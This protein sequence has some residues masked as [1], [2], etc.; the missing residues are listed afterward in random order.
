MSFTVQRVISREG[1]GFACSRAYLSVGRDQRVYLLSVAAFE[2]GW[3][4][5]LLRTHLDGSDRRGMQYTLGTDGVG[6]EGVAYAAANA[7]GYTAIADDAGSG[8]VW[9][10][11]PD[12][13]VHPLTRVGGMFAGA[14]APYRV[15]A[16]AVSGRFY[17]L[18]QYGLQDA[19]GH[20]T[21]KAQISVLGAP[22]D[23]Q[24]TGLPPIELPFAHDGTVLVTDFRVRETGTPAA[25]A[26]VFYVLYK[27]PNSDGKTFTNHLA[28]TDEHGTLLWNRDSVGTDGV[29]NTII[30]QLIGENSVGPDNGGI[31]GGF[32][33]AD[34]GHIYLLGPRGTALYQIP[35]DGTTPATALPLP[36]DAPPA[37]DAPYR[38]LRILGNQVLLQRYQDRELYGVFTLPDPATT[39][40][41]TFDR[42]VLC[43]H[44]V[45]TATFPAEAAG[46]SFWTAGSTVTAELTLS[47][48]GAG[49]P[50]TVLPAPDWK[51]WVRSVGAQDHRELAVTRV[52]ATTIQLAVPADLSG[53]FQLTL[54]PNTAPWRTGVVDGYRLR[55]F[56]EVRPAGVTGSVNISTMTPYHGDFGNSLPVP[57]PRPLNRTRYAAGEPIVVALSVRPAPSPARDLVLRLDDVSGTSPVTVAQ[58]TVVVPTTGS[59]T[60]TVPGSVTG[61]LRPGDYLLTTTA[62]DLTVAAQPI[63]LGPGRTG[64]GFRRV[65][66]GDLLPTFPTTA[67]VFTGPYAAD[68]LDSAD[69]AATHLERVRRMGWT[70]IVDRLTDAQGDLSRLNPTDPGWDRTTEAAIATTASR[71]TADPHAVDP[72]KIWALP[73][74]LDIIGGYGA[75]GVA[76]RSILLANDTFLP[77]PDLDSTTPAGT[78]P[79]SDRLANQLAPTNQILSGYP[80]FTGWHWAANWWLPYSGP[81]G[82]TTSLDFVLPDYKDALFRTKADGVWRWPLA[83]WF[84]HEAERIPAAARLLRKELTAVAESGAGRSDLVTAYAG[85]PTQPFL[86][87]PDTF[88][89][90]D[91][92]DLQNQQEQYPLMLGA[93]FWLDF[94]RRPGKAM[95]LHE[96][97]YNDSGTGD[98]V[99]GQAFEALLRGGATSG[100]AAT[101]NSFGYQQ[102][103]W[104]R[105]ED[106]LPDPRYLGAGLPGMFRALADVLR[107]YGEWVAAFASADP[108][109]ILLSRRQFA[110]Q[111]WHSNLPGHTGRV[112]EAYIS[113]LYAHIPAS[114]VFVE[115]FGAPGVRAITD[116]SAVLLINERVELD[117]EVRTA[118]AAARN[119]GVPIFHD[120]TTP[121]NGDPDKPEDGDGCLESVISGL[122]STSLGVSFG[123]S[124]TLRPNTANRDYLFQQET[125]DS[126]IFSSANYIDEPD[127]EPISW[128]GIA[129]DNVAALR[130]ALGATAGLGTGHADAADPQVLISERWHGPARIVLAVNNSIFSTDANTLG[131]DNALFRRADTLHSVRAPLT[132]TVT[133]P[134]LPAGA[135]VY[136][137]FAGTLLTPDAAGTVP[138]DLRHWP[139]AILAV[140]PSPITGV[141]VGAA[142]VVGGQATGTV[143]IE[144]SVAVAGGSDAN[145]SVPLPVRVRILDDSRDVL[146]E[147]YTQAP[148]SGTFIVPVNARGTIRVEAV[149]LITGRAGTAD[150]GVT[151][152]TGTGGTP[153]DLLTGPTP[154]G[155]ASA[156]AAVAPRTSGTL[157]GAAP[158]GDWRPAAARLGAHLS[159]VTLTADGQSAVFSAANWD[160]NLYAVDLA[161]G[162]LGW[163]S[164]IG[165]QFS[166]GPR[167]LPHAVSVIGADLT[168]PAEFGLHM[169]DPAT[170]TVQRRFDL[171]GTTPRW[172]DRTSTALTD[173][174]PPAFATAAD[175]SWVAC[176]G[177]LG[178]AAWD[179]NGTLLWSRANWGSYPIT[180]YPGRSATAVLTALNATT[181]LVID[182]RIATGY[183]A[184]TGKQVLEADLSSVLTTGNGKATA[185]VPSPD[186]TAVAVATSHD[187]GRVLI[188][189]AV[190]L[191]VRAVLATRADELAWTADGTGLITA[192]DTRVSGYRND[193]ATGW[194]LQACHP[195][196]DVV[197]NI[198]VAADGRIACGDE[199]GNLIVL[200]ASLTP[201]HTA[202]VA[203]LPVPH[204][205]PGGDLLVGTWLGLVQRLDGTYQPRWST[206]VRSTSPDMRRQFLASAAAPVASVIDHGNGIAPLTGQNLYPVATT[207]SFEPGL[208][209]QGA[210]SL[211]APNPVPAAYTPTPPKA[212]WLFDRVVETMAVGASN[213]E[214]FTLLFQFPA[215]P[216][217]HQ[218]T[219][220]QFN[221]ISLW[222]DPAHP[223]SWLRDLR[224]DVRTS[225]DRPWQPISRLISD[226]AA[227]SHRV[228]DPLAPGRPVTATEFRL[229]RPPGL[230][231]NAFRIS[232]ALHL[233][234]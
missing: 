156:S 3:M 176:A 137:V 26:P 227:R 209:G 72:A 17:A 118:L 83:A 179:Q 223:E 130:T 61:L 107:E 15:E 70:M 144:W 231:G 170:G 92:V 129:M 212:P 73:P 210:P 7:A 123:R 45:G 36:P 155:G 230:P 22:P 218:V 171:Y 48:H 194:R 60:L 226:Q 150:G 198:A 121:G 58:T 213:T 228:T 66:F 20:V 206:L 27:T 43:Q 46:G 104:M 135:A 162:A 87:P 184:T 225:P 2:R 93:P 49:T 165:H 178:L 122:G 192:Y 133:L 219:P 208:P 47:R 139:A 21:P 84:A 120:G 115:D 1:P 132:T 32:D 233:T 216:D 180:P 14:M 214:P 193:P 191:S 24:V 99:L 53:L 71:L 63:D 103:P 9:L 86:Y 207:I 23:E 157:L 145:G 131:V 181:L 136:D 116:Y 143:Q 124:Y 203:G 98:Q 140:L 186:G 163:Q 166:Y 109:A 202:D 205:L 229:V 82:L 197:H 77:L 134:T 149:E 68:Y 29:L 187:N 168:S 67:S 11:P 59:L 152:G 105:Q 12:L 195:A 52:D 188:L 220:I 100:H 62:A 177:N 127:L 18:A 8:Q 161:T 6:Y 204:W 39:G 128:V 28:K 16:G 76:L 88:A 232:I 96:E 142:P 10:F 80:A 50:D 54:T 74:L 217:T 13:P 106:L 79:I 125:C 146:W 224:L 147:Q 169:V 108:V 25:P 175:G 159:A 201:V 174:C 64:T 196:A 38:E 183:D 117:P 153:M 102:I 4:V 75:R 55:R 167:T 119:A 94:C 215:D 172:F 81:T 211:A 221:A 85:P 160:R 138:V 110:V 141:T 164:R 182:D 40:S 69:A 57:P 200:D 95:V 90:A 101:G 35:D 97:D 65:L 113:L 44:E 151:V 30:R 173:G 42:S 185:A 51:A 199:Q 78:D 112:F 148:A 31:A 111:R 154:S 234:A 89:E 33:V 91:E 19:A 56:I 34:T 222:D 41:L 158:G 189:D 37:A 126:A 190:D 114:L 5:Y